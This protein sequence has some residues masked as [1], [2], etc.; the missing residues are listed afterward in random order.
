MIVTSTVHVLV[1]H[2]GM[3]DTMTRRGDE[4][5]TGGEALPIRTLA[6]EGGGPEA[7]PVARGVTTAEREGRMMTLSASLP[8]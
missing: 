7:L 5:V 3:I 2:T 1:A 6:T 8:A 4:M